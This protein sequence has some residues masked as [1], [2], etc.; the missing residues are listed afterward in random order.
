MKET[1]LTMQSNR[2]RSML[3]QDAH[4]QA[5]VN[6]QG[7]SWLRVFLFAIEPLATLENNW[8]FHTNKGLDQH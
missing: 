3:W 5:L 7:K 8:V 4:P 6:T 2:G 1:K